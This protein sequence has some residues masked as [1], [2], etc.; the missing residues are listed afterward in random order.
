MIDQILELSKLESKKIIFNLEVTDI[1]P[2]LRNRTSAFESIA[3][4]KGVELKTTSSTS[5][6]MV[7]IDK[8]KFAIVIDN[9]ISNALKFTP[10]GGTVSVSVEA[11]KSGSFDNALIYVSD[12]GVGIPKDKLELIFE[13]FY[14]VDDSSTKK[15]E[16][17]GLGL[18]IVK[19]T[20]EQLNG[21]IKAESEVGIGTQ[22][23][24][25]L[26]L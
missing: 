16:G 10:S 7:K 2:F 22:F 9:L 15:Y 11:G 26:P 3:K 21:S 18:A 19:E 17:T 25:T 12:T 5:S 13:R 23:I 1:V 24:I 20:V 4:K 14:Q 6:L 8:E